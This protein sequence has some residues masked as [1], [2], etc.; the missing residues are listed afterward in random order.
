MVWV[1]M[2]TRLCYWYC[3]ICKK[4]LED[5]MDLELAE[6]ANRICLNNPE[7]TIDEEPDYDGWPF[8]IITKGIS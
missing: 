4:E 6:Y 2:G 8:S 5:L 7:E 1:D 3:R